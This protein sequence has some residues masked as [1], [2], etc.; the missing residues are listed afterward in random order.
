M[1]RAKY[2]AALKDSREKL[3]RSEVAMC[4]RDLV[5]GVQD[6]CGGGIVG[7]VEKSGRAG[8]VTAASAGNN[9]N[10]DIAEK[11]SLEGRVKELESDSISN[12]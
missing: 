3:Q 5:L 2:A 12:N 8:S 6:R 11:L 10:I 9:N 7:R 4:V 1:L